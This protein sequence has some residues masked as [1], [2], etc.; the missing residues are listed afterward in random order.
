MKRTRGVISCDEMRERVS[1]FGKFFGRIFTPP[2]KGSA[3]KKEGRVT[4]VAGA[5]SSPQ[6]V[7]QSPV[8]EAQESRLKAILRNGW[9]AVN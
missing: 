3:K 7:V 5:V 8:V 4:T 2:A 6:T 9:H 1:E